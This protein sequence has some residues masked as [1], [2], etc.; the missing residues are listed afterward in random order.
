[1]DNFDLKKY[2]AEG[3]LHEENSNQLDMFSPEEEAYVDP[4]K[5]KA[6]QRY[7]D[8]GG[9]VRISGIGKPF[10]QI[11][12]IP[13][14]EYTIVEGDMEGRWS[15]SKFNV[16]LLKPMKPFDLAVQLAQETG[17]ISPWNYLEMRKDHDRELKTTFTFPLQ[18][19]LFDKP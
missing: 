14:G 11:K 19:T 2:L 13:K 18:P 10:E 7:K 6:E 3:K 5:K 16:T 9:S 4:I 8:H 15:Y 12:V 1:M 17:W